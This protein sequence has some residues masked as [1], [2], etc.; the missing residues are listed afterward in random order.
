MLESA[1]RLL[2]RIRTEEGG[3]RAVSLQ[4]LIKTKRTLAD[5]AN[6][7]MAGSNFESAYKKLVGDIDSAIERSII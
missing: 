5:V 1:E 7:E 2:N 6:W 3:L 4:E